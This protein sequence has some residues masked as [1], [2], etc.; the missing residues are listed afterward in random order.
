MNKLRALWATYGKSIIAVA[1]AVYT[2]I[3]A[4]ISDGHI[5]TAEGIQ[6]AIATATAV[7]V[8]LVPLHP[9]ATWV[10]TAIAVLLAVLNVVAATIAAGTGPSVSSVLLAALTALGVTISPAQSTVGTTVPPAAAR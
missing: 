8:W 5:T 10:K 9:Q 7:A 2:A 3:S 6:I 1:F 4:A